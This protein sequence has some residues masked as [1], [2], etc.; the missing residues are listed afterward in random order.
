MPNAGAE[1]PIPR[2][3][4]PPSSWRWIESSMSLVSALRTTS[5]SCPSIKSRMPFLKKSSSISTSSS[6]SSPPA[7][8]FSAS[9]TAR[10]MSERGLPFSLTKAAL[11]PSL[12][13]L[14]TVVIGNLMS[15]AAKVPPTT[16]RK[17]GTLGKIQSSEPVSTA[18]PTTVIPMTRPRRVAISIVFRS[19]AFQAAAGITPGGARRPATRPIFVSK[20]G[21]LRF[22]TFATML[23]TMAFGKSDCIS[24]ESRCEL[25]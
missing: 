1:S 5:P 6:A 20:S 19:L 7:R 22:A 12:N 23:A 8:V 13:A 4:L 9:D 15:V 3:I 11:T 24:R 2:K 17:L 18:R 21:R 16:M 14:N 25:I 10:S